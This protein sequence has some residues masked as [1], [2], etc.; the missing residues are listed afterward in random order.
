[1]ALAFWLAFTCICVCFFM[2]EE[3]WSLLTSMYV[4]AQILTTV[5]YGDLTVTHT[6]TKVLMALYVL[7]CLMVFA[8]FL[9]ASCQTVVNSQVDF[10]RQKLRKVEVAAGDGLT[11]Q[12]AMKKYGSLNAF[13]VQTAMCKNEYTVWKGCAATI[14][15]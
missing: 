3:G 13:I 4:T 2:Y 12:K 9:N 10:L 6:P 1:M 14:C 11:E 7:S 8:Y 5:G 15:E